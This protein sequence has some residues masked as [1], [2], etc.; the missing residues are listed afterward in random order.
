MEFNA[1]FLISAISFILFTLIMNK[2]F[3]KPLE[4]VMDE[5]QKFI[6]DTKSDAEKSN[7]KAQAIINDREERLTKSATDSKKLVAD[8]INEANENS[9][10]IT[11][12][13][14]QKSQEEIASAKSALKN[15]AQQ[16]TEELK[17]KV[18]DLAEVISS[19]ILG[20]NTNI[21]NIDNEIVNRILN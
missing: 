11:S 4:R 8:K 19:K 13:A 15:E 12:N 1:T 2:I 3:Y 6:D 17:L 16:T 20:M 18:K 7:L 5:R 21:E 14:K 9:K 10:I